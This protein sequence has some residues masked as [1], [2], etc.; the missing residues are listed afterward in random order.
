MNRADA[1]NAE[2]SLARV[3]LFVAR[4]AA[5]DLDRLAIPRPPQLAR[6]IDALETAIV[7]VAHLC[8]VCRELFNVPTAVDDPQCTTTVTEDDARV[9]CPPCELATRPRSPR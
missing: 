2:L 1:T 8:P 9:L 7:D 5:G 3:R 6:L 4:R